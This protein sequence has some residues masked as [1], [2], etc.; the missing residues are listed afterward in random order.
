MRIEASICAWDHGEG[1]AFYALVS[2]GKSKLERTYAVPGTINQAEIHAARFALAAF[3]RA[4]SIK[5]TTDS[6]YLA[7]L[8]ERE[9]KAWVKSVQANVDRV[10]ALRT[11]ISKIPFEVQKV[12]SV[13]H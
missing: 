13:P 2:D 5:I 10:E 4:S 3:P 9:G 6:Y 8:L 7:G 12:S 1:A 11:A